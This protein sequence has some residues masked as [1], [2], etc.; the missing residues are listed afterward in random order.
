MGRGRR[1]LEK[2][3]N[4]SSV[5]SKREIVTTMGPVWFI[6]Q[7]LLFSRGGPLGTVPLMGMVTTATTTMMTMAAQAYL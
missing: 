1:A 5:G 7:S 2:M 6:V 3:G 4:R